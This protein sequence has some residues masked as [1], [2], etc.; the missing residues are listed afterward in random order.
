MGR[1][2]RSF[3]ANNKTTRQFREQFSLLPPAV[4]ALVWATCVVFERDPSHPS[5]RSH[6][7][8]ERGKSNALPDS[9]SVSIT[10]KYRAIYVVDNGINYWYWIGSHAD[11][12]RF[13]GG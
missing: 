5:L 10:M 6:R 12:D 9:Y 1:L 8:D 13:T 3:R 4:Q 11:Y 7:L 2:S